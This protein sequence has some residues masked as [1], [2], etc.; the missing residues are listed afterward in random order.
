MNE[1][2]YAYVNFKAIEARDKVIKAF[3]DSKVCGLNC[4]VIY[5]SVNKDPEMMLYDKSLD[6]LLVCDP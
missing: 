1:I 6:V 5:D 4:S 3:R 2:K